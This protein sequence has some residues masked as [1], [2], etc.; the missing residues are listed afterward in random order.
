MHTIVWLSATELWER[1]TYYGM[2]ALLV[3]HL[4]AA[5]MTGG[6]GLGD[7]DAA[8]IYGL[9]VA[10]VYLAALPG[11]A[12]ADRYVGP[13]NAIWWGG[14]SIAA[15]NAV[16]ATADSRWMLGSGLALIALGVGLLKPNVTALVARAAAREGRSIDAAFTVFYVGINVGGVGGPLLAAAFSR[17]FGW[18]AGY[19]VAAVGMLI[20]LAAFSRIAPRLREPRDAVR[21][22][23]GRDLLL[24]SAVLVA[25]AVAVSAITPTLLARIALGAVLVAAVAGFAWLTRIAHSDHE[26]RAVRRLALLFIGATAFWAAGEQAGISLTL[27]AQ[28]F[29]DRTVLGLEFPAAWYQ[30][31]YPGYVVLFAPLAAWLWVA[32][33]R[34]NGD[35]SAVVKFGFGLLFGAA[36]L[37]I[38]AAGA[39]GA[40]ANGASPAWLAATYLFLAIGEILLSPIGLGAATR[41]APA[42]HVGFATGLWFLSLS[43]GGLLAGVTGGLFDLGT[44]EGLA[45]ALISIGCVLA[46]VGVVFALTA[47]R[48]GEGPRVPRVSGAAD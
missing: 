17:A 7:A 18:G 31:L 25:L 45:T 28:R 30:S 12:I 1:F 15:G 29:T 48:F 32:L 9:F 22:P 47:R 35:P 36:A 4:V 14:A 19:A 43:L 39:S 24:G 11:G 46:V 13:I 8:A 34:R 27:F 37:F 2:R 40:G 44:T 3:L 33:A 41:Y 6:F 20:G 21:R 10:G 23:A 38:A 42:G 5:P 16:L 26:R